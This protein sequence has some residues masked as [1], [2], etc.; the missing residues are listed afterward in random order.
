[1]NRETWHDWFVGMA[2]RMSKMISMVRLPGSLSRITV[3]EYAEQDI[4]KIFSA[5]KM[6]NLRLCVRAASEKMHGS[7]FWSLLRP[8]G[9][10]GLCA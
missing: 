6:K 1:M 9:I 8:V 4:N 2:A 5:L 10:D 7:Y 3:Y